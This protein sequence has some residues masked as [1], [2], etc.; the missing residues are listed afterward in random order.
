MIEFDAI[1]IATGADVEVA[2][3]TKK[4]LEYKGFSVRVVSM[5]CR[6]LFEKQDIAYKEKILPT[7][8][9]TKVSVEAGVTRCFENLT[10]MAGSSIGVNTFGESGSGAE[11][12]DLFGFSALN[13][14]NVVQNLIIKNKSKNA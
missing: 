13:I 10:G 3:N 11:L 8:F 7:N 5:P 12:Y 4:L 14:G 1:L 6:E 2:L 9:L